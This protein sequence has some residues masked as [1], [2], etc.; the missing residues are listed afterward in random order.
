MTPP[1]GAEAMAA[2]RLWPGD[3]LTEQ[4]A[5]ACAR[6]RPGSDGRTTARASQEE[7]TA[8]AAAGRRGLQ[9]GRGE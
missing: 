5:T 4:G 6:A 2:C 9:S 8:A 7:K 3:T 1:A